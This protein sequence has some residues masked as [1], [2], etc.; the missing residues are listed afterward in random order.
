M[1]SRLPDS[2]AACAIA[3]PSFVGG[4]VDHEVPDH[5]AQ[6]AAGD[7]DDHPGQHGAHHAADADG[8]AEAPGQEA[9]GRASRRRCRL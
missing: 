9:P 7:R 4:R 8:A 5:L 1:L 2:R 3:G 6:H